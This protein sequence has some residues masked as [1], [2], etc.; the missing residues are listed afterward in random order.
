MSSVNGRMVN[1]MQWNISATF[2]GRLAGPLLQL[3]VARLLEPAAFGLFAVVLVF[4]SFAEV[5]R[6]FGVTQI[7]VMRQSPDHHINYQFTLQLGL[8]IVLAFVAL[9]LAPV[10][11]SALQLDALSVLLPLSALVLFATAISDPLGAL[12]LK[13]Q[14]YKAYALRQVITP[15]VSG[16][17][18]WLLAANGYGVYALVIGLIAG[19][20]ATALLMWLKSNHQLRLQWSKEDV[21]PLLSGGR[22]IMAQRMSGFLINSLDAIPISYNL[23]TAQVGIYRMGGQ[24]AQL[25]PNIVLPQAIQVLFTEFSS[26]KDKTQ[27]QRHFDRYVMIA[28]PAS[29][30]YA[31]AAYLLA[32]PLIPWLLGPQWVA[33]VPVIQLM[34]AT[35]PTGYLAMLNYETA[36]SMAVVRPFTYYSVLRSIVT[37]GAII[38][39]SM[40]SFKAVVF[41]AACV[42]II[43]TL[44]NELVF[45]RS[46]KA[47]R[48]LASKLVIL[49][50]AL[51]WSIFVAVSLYHSPSWS[52]G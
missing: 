24:L 5:I 52:M 36:R 23:G 37:L 12:F 1:N 49:C 30:V 46:Q 8:A 17:V 7:F 31:I 50:L 39:A 15:L 47:V 16:L 44:V 14:N 22:H 10:A 38:V 42:A 9:I 32:P 48:L 20:Y 6:D 3:L 13:K 51:A 40:Y 2:L 29:I 21:A 41:S 33:L 11:A 19:H 4:V 25:G 27:I 35:V 43:A 45:Y 26:F 28:G 18:A 34:S